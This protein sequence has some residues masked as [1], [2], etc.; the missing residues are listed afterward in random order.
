M[1]FAIWLLGVAFSRIRIACNAWVRYAWLVPLLA[2][3]AYFRLTADNDRFDATTL[4]MDLLLSL[5]FLALLS[6]LQFGAASTSRIAKPL[7]GTAR[8]FAEFSFSLYVL[9]LPLIFLLQHLVQ[10]HLGLTQLSPDAPLHFALYLAMLGTLLVSS[11]L[12]YLLFESQTYRLRRLIKGL[13][14]RRTLP[15]PGAATASVNA[16]SN[17]RR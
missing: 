12:S 13:A 11:Y 17:T 9:H 7:A 5:M 10:A 8:F 3:S 4:G 2:A 1:Y 15:L 16:S 14:G 6:S